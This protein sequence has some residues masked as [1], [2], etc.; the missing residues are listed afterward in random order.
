MRQE[1]KY[2]KF[3]ELHEGSAH[4]KFICFTNN[5]EA[6]KSIGE[7]LFSMRVGSIVYKQAKYI[8]H[9]FTSQTLIDIADFLK[10]VNMDAGLTTP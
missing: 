1:Y 10:Q 6:S 4:R 9:D 2:I 5:G 7:V 8:E 3:I